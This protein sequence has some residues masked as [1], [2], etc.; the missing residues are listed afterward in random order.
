MGWAT[1]AY[2]DL[3]RLAWGVRKDVALQEFE[4]AVVSGRLLGGWRLEPTLAT[5]LARIPS[6]TDIRE[7]RFLHTFFALHH[8]HGA[9]VELGPYLGGTTRAIA[10]GME[11]AGSSGPLISLDAFEWHSPPL[12]QRLI[13]DA[14]GLMR[15]VGIDPELVA[16]VHGGQW[17]RL[18]EQVHGR[19]TYGHLVH[20]LVAHF[21]DR[22]EQPV[23]AGLVR[24]VEQLDEL[25]CIFVDGLKSWPSMVHVL[26]LLLPRLSV[27]GFFILQD[28]SWYDCF[29]LPVLLGYL[30]Q[31]F[32]LVHKVVNTATFRCTAPV[33]DGV[34]AGFPDTPEGYGVEGITPFLRKWA[35]AA[36]DAGDEWGAIGHSMQ[37]ASAQAW[38]G[39]PDEAARLTEALRRLPLADGHGWLFDA[40]DA[41]PV[42]T[43]AL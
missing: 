41:G 36:L 14:A 7:R 1:S 31:Q 42:M 15:E 4:R 5:S 26:R 43:G 38:F 25:S 23:P 8:L 24:S 32:R 39:S 11:R 40:F 28:F 29:W 6:M 9:V 13:D 12:R 17:L 34:L 10:T 27:G 18:F 33:H 20:P 3:N 30:N 2:P 22:P 19:E 16:E 37:L 21:P 35:T